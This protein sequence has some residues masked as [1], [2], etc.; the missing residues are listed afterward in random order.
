VIRGK[1]KGVDIFERK[2]AS[3]FFS[4]F[5]RL[6]VREVDIVLAG[7]ERWNGAVVLR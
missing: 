7:G 2:K 1:R 3:T 4:F 6:T 5:L